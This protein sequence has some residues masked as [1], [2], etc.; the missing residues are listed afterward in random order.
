[1]SRS[2]KAKILYFFFNSTESRTD[3]MRRTFERWLSDSIAENPQEID[4]LMGELWDTHTAE[5]DG[6]RDRKGLN[7]LHATIRQDRSASLRKRTVRIA[8]AAVAAA[9]MFSGG[10]FAAGLTKEV[11]E[12]I[13]LIT[14]HDNIGE[15]TLPDGTKVWLSGEGK[16]SF[17]KDFSRELREVTLCGEAFFDVAREADRPFHVNMNGVRI[18]VLGTSFD[19]SNNDFSR[20][21]EVVLKT[22]VIKVSGAGFSE[23]LYMSPDQKLSIDKQTGDYSVENVDADNYC[24][25]FADRLVFDNHRLCDI[26]TTLERRYNVEMSLS[27]GLADDMRMSF[28]V[29][30]RD[31]LDD[32]LAMISELISADYRKTRHHIMFFRR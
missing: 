21:Q 15:Y 17:P 26:V 3:K 25:W 9:A 6:Q 16:L 19:V 7:R 31:S 32:I 4:V 8:A 10:Y 29:N 23:P 30:S 24:N 13:S 1:M 20:N 14:A 27:P 22:G 5:P 2:L 28:V 12:E 18:E 11:R